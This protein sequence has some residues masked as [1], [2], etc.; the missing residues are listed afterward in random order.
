VEK[1]FTKAF[2]KF[3]E[4]VLINWADRE[5][6]WFLVCDYRVG[7]HEDTITVINE[8]RLYPFHVP[9]N[10]VIKRGIFIKTPDIPM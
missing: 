4:W 9:Y 10:L 5:P 7:A 6:E 8:R 2:I 1:K 3:G